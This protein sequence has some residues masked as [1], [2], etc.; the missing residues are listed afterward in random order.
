MAIDIQ[1]LHDRLVECGFE[2]LIPNDPETATYERAVFFNSTKYVNPGGTPEIRILIQL[3]ADGQYLEAFA[4]MAF[5]VRDCRYKGAMFALAMQI[6]YMTKYLQCEY[7]PADGEIRVA[8]DMPVCDGDVTAAQIRELVLTIGANLEHYAPVFNHAMETGKID[9]S[10]A[11]HEDASER[12]V[13]S[14]EVAALLEAIGGIESL[15]EIAESRR[16]QDGSE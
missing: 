15:R 13:V 1:M 10:L 2:V 5:N 12:P 7:D 4:P 14:D 8:A 3:E 6:S 9:F 16:E 11:Q